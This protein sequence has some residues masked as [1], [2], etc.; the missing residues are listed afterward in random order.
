MELLWSHRTLGQ[1]RQA[2]P[3]F[4]KLAG[5]VTRMLGEHFSRILA[6]RGATP[7][8]LSLYPRGAGVATGLGGT[9]TRAAA[10]GGGMGQGPAP[11]KDAL[12]PR[13]HSCPCISRAAALAAAAGG[14]GGGGSGLRRAGGA[15]AAAPTSSS[16]GGGA[17]VLFKRQNWERLLFP[18]KKLFRGATVGWGDSNAWGDSI[19]FDRNSTVK[20]TDFQ[21]QIFS[22][23]FV[24]RGDM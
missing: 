19:A 22:Y 13:G 16:G 4:Q 6:A 8:H 14:W 24:R 2:A 5:S 20:T 17:E 7:A 23:P 10:C 21:Q 12:G 3:K 9:G 15:A 1:T 18:P 11:K